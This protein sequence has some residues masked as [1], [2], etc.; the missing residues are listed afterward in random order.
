MSVSVFDEYLQRF[1]GQKLDLFVRIRDQQKSSL[2]IYSC[3]KLNRIS[4]TFR[5]LEYLPA[6]FRHVSGK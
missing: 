1:E 3:S 5:K 4:H 6:E 2:T